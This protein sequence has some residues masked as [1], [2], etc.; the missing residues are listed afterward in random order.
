MS[1]RFENY[2]NKNNLQL[3]KPKDLDSFLKTFPFFQAVEKKSNFRRVLLDRKKG[4]I[5]F[6]QF[7]WSFSDDFSTFLNSV[8]LC[9]DT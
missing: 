6:S 3:S 7:S 2:V 5:F 9:Y 1:L 8:L 4:K